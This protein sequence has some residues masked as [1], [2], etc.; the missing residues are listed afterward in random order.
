MAD[1]RVSEGQHALVPVSAASRQT[2]ASLQDS[3]LAEVRTNL[4]SSSSGYG[5]QREA[6]D[7]GAVTPGRCGNKERRAEM[8]EIPDA[9]VSQWGSRSA[10]TYQGFGSP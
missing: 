6:S 5:R 1:H 4:P 3:T 9:R 2:W 8:D 10:T 7:S